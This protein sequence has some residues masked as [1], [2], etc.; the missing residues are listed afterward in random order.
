M[1]SF[2]SAP[3]CTPLNYVAI[4]VHVHLLMFVHK[5]CEKFLGCCIP[6]KMLIYLP[7]KLEVEVGILP[8]K[9]YSIWPPIATALSFPTML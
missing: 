4:H 2:Y 1:G 7:D 5:N 9:Q 6:E 8:F 3:S